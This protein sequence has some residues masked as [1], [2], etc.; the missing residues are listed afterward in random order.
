MNYQYWFGT[1]QA[2][3]GY[4]AML[5]GFKS[6]LPAGVE[7][8]DRASVA[9]MMYD[10]SK[11]HGFLKGQY[12]ALYS[13]WETTEL[14]FTY[15]RN[16]KAYDKIIVPCEHNRE[17]FSQYHNNVV[18]VPLGVD[19]NYW[20]PVTRPD[21]SRLRFHAGG[22]TWLRKGLDVVV[23]AFQLADIDAELHI[24][25]PLKR[26]IPDRVWPSNITIHTGF[27]S[28]KEQMDWYK[29]ADCF[30]A[31]S[32]GE[33]FGL[34]PLQAM[35]MGIPTIITA[36]SGQAQYADLASITIPTKPQKSDVHEIIDFE[37]YWDEPN[38]D[39]LVSAFKAMSMNHAI[40]KARAMAQVYEVSR[41]G[42]DVSCR[43]LLNEL[44]V[45]SLL[46]D[47]I[48]EPFVGY[49]KIRVNRKCEAGINSEQWYFVPNVDYTVT[50]TVY[51]IL[52]RANYIQSQE[53]V[54]RSDNYA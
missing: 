22:S 12:R 3:Y 30:V 7:L 43:K 32:R 46:D 50:N 36:T 40:Y 25:V 34:M 20:K 23:E 16:L 4:G 48:Y 5:E 27:M 28:K 35:A 18:T 51:D 9:V 31:A 24:K 13:M 33:G 19:L 11:S 8:H 26:F 44:P 15:Y 39:A 53:T 21:N 45:G 6:G 1:T 14:P 29:Q 52:A 38:L 2:N 10:P 47:A 49:Q 41:Y 42:W 37:G 17:L 54:E